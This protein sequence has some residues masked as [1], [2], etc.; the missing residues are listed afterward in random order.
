MC[1]CDHEDD[2]SR[3]EDLDTLNSRIA[4]LKHERYLRARHNDDLRIE[5]EKMRK[6]VV[7]ARKRYLRLISSR[8]VSTWIFFRNLVG[9]PVE[10]IDKSVPER[11]TDDCY[12]IDDVDV[13]FAKVCEGFAS[14][15][16]DSEG[17]SYFEKLPVRV[18]IITD[19]YMY[20]Y[21]SGIVDLV[22]LSPDEYVDVM[23][24]RE[25]DCVMFVTCWKGMKG[26]DYAGLDGV[27]KASE[28]LSYAR[29]NGIVTVFQSIEDPP[30]YERFLPVAKQADVIFTSAMEMVEEYKRDT[31]CEKV[32][33]LLYG[34]NPLLQNPVGFCRKRTAALG[35]LERGVFFAGSW[36]PRYPDRCRMMKLIFDGIENSDGWS[37]HI[38]D[39]NLLIPSHKD[40][41]FPRAY[42]DGLMPPVEHRLLQKVH[43][44]FD[45]TV[46]LN[47]VTDSPTMCAMRVYEV[48]ALGSLMITNYAYSVSR[49]FPGL[50]T[51]FDSDEVGRILGGYTD[52]EILSMQ[53]EGIRDVYSR[54]TAFDRLNQV[55]EA[56]GVEDRFSVRSVLVVF[57]EETE[58]AREFFARQVC[59]GKEL[60]PPSGASANGDGFM[61]RLPGSGLPTS[62]V[63]LLDL[64]NAF[65]FADADYVR[66]AEGG[67]L[68]RAYEY[69]FDDPSPEGVLFD[70]RK[71]D[72][73]G[74][75][76]GELPSGLRGFEVVEPRWGRDT[77]ATGKDLAVIVPVYNNGGYLWKRCFRSLMRSSAFERMRVYLVDDGSTDGVTPMVVRW[78]SETFD[79]VTAYFFGEGG[80]GSASRARNKGF[81]LSS[82]PF[83]TYLDPDNEAVGD[84]YAALLGD[85]EA[86]DVDFAFGPI[87]KVVPQL[88]HVSELRWCDDEGV[89]DCGPAALAA[90][91]FRTQSIQGCVVRRSLIAENGIE[92]PVGAVGQDTLFFYE[93]VIHADRAYHRRLPIHVYYAD[94]EGSAVNSVSPSFFE[95]SYLCEERQARVFEDA[96]LLGE[97]RK[98]KLDD[99]M[100]GWY[101]GKLELVDEGDLPECRRIVDG[102]RRL[103]G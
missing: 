52:D 61:I 33:P 77:S 6:A 76:A 26:S 15:I 64:V 5:V 2:A 1:R 20:N 59:P 19:E 18:G 66:Y 53:I 87:L 13:N 98:V 88:P 21:Y 63:Y 82:E 46:N 62:P 24:K 100:E 70:L 80:S 44:I 54:H 60:L 35:G 65:K 45:F 12:T 75:V 81:E 56:V 67:S 23:E 71:V 39:R 49:S 31:G 50:F 99:F 48:Q 91:G 68:D 102:I 41:A 95:R 72:A 22:Y 9:K 92:S 90:R 14:R 38:A 103:Y 29:F 16:A 10:T 57:D 11:L 7:S 93:M 47:S 32:E 34:V 42:L 17:G 55:F 97:Y 74:I 85:L 79:N 25:V 89:V 86:H 73:R 30:N 78:I 27:R 94:R 101:G 51:V 43:K 69:C 58:E 8:W 28:V 37:L 84:G 83:V 4:F 96:G 36:A 40:Y 3:C